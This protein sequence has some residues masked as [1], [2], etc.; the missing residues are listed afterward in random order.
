MVA[1][2]KF[3]RENGLHL[4]SMEYVFTNPPLCINEQQ[5][6]EAFRLLIKGWRLRIVR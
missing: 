5:M 2:G 4:R 6:R 1:L 3:F